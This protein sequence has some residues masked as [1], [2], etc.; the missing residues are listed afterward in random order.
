MLQKCVSECINGSRFKQSPKYIHPNFDLI[1]YVT[2]IFDTSTR[3]FSL[4]YF[5]GEMIRLGPRYN[6]PYLSAEGQDQLSPHVRLVSS[7]GAVFLSSALVLAASS[8]FMRRS[9]LEGACQEEDSTTIS[10]EISTSHLSLFC[11]FITSGYLRVSKL[12]PCLT[13]SF[14]TM[15]VDLSRM[16]LD[17]VEAIKFEPTNLSLLKEQGDE[18][19]RPL[20]RRAQKR[21]A[22]R[23]TKSRSKNVGDHSAEVKEEIVEFDFDGSFGDV[24]LEDDFVK[25][26]QRYPGLATNSIFFCFLFVKTH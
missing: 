17:Q 3:A 13:E 16:K 7:D 6:V 14:S 2:Q 10:T 1:E 18:E 5:S 25:G 8:D 22:C 15:G 20:K 23:A 11:D 9:L 21:K 24:N 26:N 4:L 12:D 19:D